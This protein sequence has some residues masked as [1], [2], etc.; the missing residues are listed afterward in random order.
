MSIPCAPRLGHASVVSDRSARGKEGDSL[1][2]IAPELS[3]LHV[4]IRQIIPSRRDR[5][6]RPAKS[7]RRSGPTIDGT[8]V[9]PPQKSSR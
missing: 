8:V 6:L 5:F 2:R 1:G 3:H 4:S 9:G 7:S